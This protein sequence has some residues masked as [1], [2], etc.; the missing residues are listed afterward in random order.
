MQLQKN[1][2]ISSN[3]DASSE[4]D[5]GINLNGLNNSIPFARALQLGRIS[6]AL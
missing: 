5:L 1:E 2:V 3:S 6:R 4:Q